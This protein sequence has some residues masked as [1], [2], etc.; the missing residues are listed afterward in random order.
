MG[1]RMD[2]NSPAGL[3]YIRN[4]SYAAFAQADWHLTKKFTVTTGARATREDRETT[5]D[6]LITINGDGAALNPV[7]T[8]SGVQLG[9]FASSATGA[10]GRGANSAAQLSLAD[11]VANRYFASL[12][13]RFRCGL[14]PITSRQQAQ[15]AAAKAIR[16]SQLG[17][18][19][20][21]TEAQP[22]KKT[23]P[24]FVVS[25]SYKFSDTKRVTS[26]AVR[27]E[28]RHRAGCPTALPISWS[29]KRIISYEIGLK[30]SL[31]H[32]TPEPSMRTFT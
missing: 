6:S 25:P 10:L 30:S 18:V 11:Q 5:S 13:H 3:Q 14:R 4:K 21:P 31:L 2:Y 17:V 32:R 26:P 19:Y 24:A 16:L 29:R 20:G 1:W 15:V 22:F 7:V 12:S 8:P 27:R 9:G 28:S 23:Q